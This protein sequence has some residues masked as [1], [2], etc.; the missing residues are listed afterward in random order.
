[1][2]Q[3][4]VFIPFVGVGCGQGHGMRLL[5]SLCKNYIVPSQRFK[6][7]WKG[8]LFTY[9]STCICIWQNWQW[10]FLYQLLFF[11]PRKAFILKAVRLLSISQ[12]CMNKYCLDDALSKMASIWE[13]TAM[14]NDVNIYPQSYCHFDLVGE[15]NFII[16]NALITIAF[17]SCFIV[18]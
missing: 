2:I 6:S 16:W 15:H 11:S 1:M 9:W 17:V 13:N 8:H 3:K 5:A 18:Y 7:S 10:G 12:G 4:A 14:E